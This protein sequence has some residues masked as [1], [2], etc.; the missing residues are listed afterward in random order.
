MIFTYIFATKKRRKMLQRFL[1]LTLCYNSP[2]NIF[3]VNN[4]YLLRFSNFNP[5]AS[6]KHG[7]SNSLG[8]QFPILPQRAKVPRHVLD[9]A[10]E[11]FENIS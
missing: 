3:Y 7:K 6:A 2:L 11:Q 10:T 4:K 8:K 9:N 1:L 5:S